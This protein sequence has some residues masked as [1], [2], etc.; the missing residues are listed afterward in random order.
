MATSIRTNLSNPLDAKIKL[1]RSFPRLKRY[2]RMT[3]EEGQGYTSSTKSKSVY[4]RDLGQDDS[5]LANVPTI[6]V[7]QPPNITTLS[8]WCKHPLCLAPRGSR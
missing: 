3:L 6:D 8:V 7:D 5:Y 4:P 1:I 2:T